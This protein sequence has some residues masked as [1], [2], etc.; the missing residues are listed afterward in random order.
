MIPT[1]GSLGCPPE[2]SPLPIFG[3]GKLFFPKSDAKIYT[4]FCIDN[5]YMQILSLFKSRKSNMQFY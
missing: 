5:E 4:I 1:K 3:T 2:I